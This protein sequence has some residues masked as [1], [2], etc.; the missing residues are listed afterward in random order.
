MLLNCL[1]TSYCDRTLGDESLPERLSKVVRYK[2][3][4]SLTATSIF[5]RINYTLHAM[6]H[7]QNLICPQMSLPTMSLA[8]NVF[9]L[10]V[11]VRS[12]VAH[13]VKEPFRYCDDKFIRRDLQK[14]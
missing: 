6:C 4:R 10:N 11:F 14:I 8:C 3:V 1:A 7:A 12:V 2:S 9:D 5:T 13:N